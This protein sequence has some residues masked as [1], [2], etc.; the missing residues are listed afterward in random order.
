MSFNTAIFYDIENLTKGYRF[1]KE[2]EQNLSL[3][4]IHKAITRSRL[5]DRI[6]FSRAYANW[7]EPRMHFMR[8]EILELAIDAIQVFGITSTGG[9]KNVADIQLTVDV[10][11][12]LHTHPHIQTFVIV[13]GDGGYASLV[14]KLHE[15]GKS[16]IGCGYARSTNRIFEA[17]CDDFIEIQD[18]EDLAYISERAAA[19]VAESRPR[20]ESSRETAAKKEKVK[21]AEVKLE[22]APKK[23]VKETKTVKEVVAVQ[24]QVVK[25]QPTPKKEVIPTPAPKPTL[26]PQPVVETLPVVVE[27]AVVEPAPA[28]VVQTEKPK[29]KAKGKA[30]KEIKKEVV[31]ETVVELAAPAKDPEVEQWLK[32]QNIGNTV[33]R[34][35]VHSVGV[36]WGEISAKEGEQKIH[37]IMAWLAKHEKF[38][39]ELQR[40]VNPSFF[41]EALRATMPSFQTQSLG[42]SRFADLLRYIFGDGEFCIWQS[43][44]Q[45]SDIKIGLRSFAIPAHQMMTDV[46]KRDSHSHDAYKALLESGNPSFREIDLIELKS[47]FHQVC[48]GQCDGLTFENSVEKI[49]RGLKHQ[50]EDEHV[51]N[52]LH[53]LLAG[54]VMEGEPSGS[55]HNNQQL[56]FIA[57][58]K[59]F[60]AAIT[61]IRHKMVAKVVGQLGSCNEE[62]IDLFF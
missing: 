48:E 50:L 21:P 34:E 5:I 33:I 8:T 32:E 22:S 25:S 28:E 55:H 38:T 13:S 24:P 35:L 29:A 15:Y 59:E 31:T 23:E 12:I 61:Q 3:K 60:D 62:L 44:K 46:E 20:R 57:Q 18:P 17:V 27:V 40:G 53:T 14:K 7:A 2:I 6:S 41:R 37:G 1:G 19:I 30:K 54:S 26:V 16:V 43:E 52:I 11:D 4:K 56:F 49:G 51:R 36:E 10:I 45:A 58:F 42:Y 9:I 39:T 47:I